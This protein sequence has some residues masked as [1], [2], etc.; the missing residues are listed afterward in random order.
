MAKHV[1][2]NCNG[3]IERRGTKVKFCS[4]ECVREFK[5]GAKI[6][7]P[8]KECG[9]EVECR[10]TN[11]RKFCSK[12][13]SVTYSNKRRERSKWSTPKEQVSCLVCKNSTVNKKFCSVKCSRTFS[14]IQYIEQWKSGE[15]SGT[16][17]KK[18]K[19]VSGHIRTHLFEINN[20][21]CQT[22]GWDSINPHTKTLPLEIHHIDGDYLN[23]RP[24]NL[25]LICPNCHSLTKGYKGANA[26]KGNSEKRIGGGREDH[27]KGD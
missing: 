16:V 3:K 22:C 11:Q 10:E 1:C 14:R 23:N 26:G 27:W 4:P 18:F 19:T 8:C 15:K 24:E 13:C 17:G 25:Q 7:I 5:F 21:S 20:N 9:I 2:K 6:L 12:S